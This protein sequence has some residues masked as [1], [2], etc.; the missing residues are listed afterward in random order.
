MS[1]TLSK[2]IIKNEINNTG[3]SHNATGGR[4]ELRAEGGVPRGCDDERL[5]EN[6]LAKF[7]AMSDLEKADFEGLLDHLLSQKKTN[8]YVDA[9]LPIHRESFG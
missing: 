5:A 9:G 2:H 3:Q 6:L 4:M 8:L 7:D 1:A